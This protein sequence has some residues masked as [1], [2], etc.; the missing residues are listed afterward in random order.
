MISQR[1]FLKDACVCFVMFRYFPSALDTER[2]RPFVNKKAGICLRLLI[3]SCPMD[4][5]DTS[6]H[7]TFLLLIFPT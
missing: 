1:H 3:R 7:V 6:N 4:I 2:N 5:N